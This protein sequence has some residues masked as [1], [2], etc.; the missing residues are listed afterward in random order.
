VGLV[1]LLG[2]GNDGRGWLDRSALVTE[3][4]EEAMVGLG[5]RKVPESAAADAFVRA[6][7]EYAPLYS[8]RLGSA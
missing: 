7:L 6:Q 4:W 8:R 5:K 3:D 2:Q 1:N